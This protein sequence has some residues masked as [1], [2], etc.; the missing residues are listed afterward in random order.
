MPVSNV[1][2]RHLLRLLR[3]PVGVHARY[4][5]PF[6]AAQLRKSLEQED[7]V[8]L[9]VR[10]DLE[11]L[12]DSLKAC[13]ALLRQHENTIQGIHIDRSATMAVAEWAQDTG[14]REQLGLLLDRAGS[15][16]SAVMRDLMEQLEAA[17]VAVLGIKADR[18]LTGVDTDE[19]LQERLRLPEPV[20]GLLTRLAEV[21]RVVVLIDQVDALSLSLSRYQRTLD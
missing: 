1:E 8:L 12:K 15:G 18:Q 9:A 13:A 2:S 16:K 4:H 21:E 19:A 10:M 6:Y 20:L 5:K 3:D 11:V 14:S 17:G 7:R